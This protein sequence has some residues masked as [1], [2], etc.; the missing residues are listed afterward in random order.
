MEIIIRTQIKT[1]LQIHDE[2]IIYFLVYYI[3]DE[4]HRS[5]TFSKESIRDI[6]EM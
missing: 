1:I 2:D 5:I 4:Y 3:Y 6:E